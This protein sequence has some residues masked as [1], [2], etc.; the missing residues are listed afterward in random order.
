MTN[1]SAPFI[2]ENNRLRK[3]L[4]R[5]SEKEIFAWHKNL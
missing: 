1:M 2:W 3:P 5:L 4:T